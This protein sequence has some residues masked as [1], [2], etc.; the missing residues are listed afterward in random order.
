MCG[1]DCT[2]YSKRIHNILLCLHSSIKC[3]TFG[4][5]GKQKQAKEHS[6]V[7]DNN[8]PFA[9]GFEIVLHCR[10]FLLGVSCIGYQLPCPIMHHVMIKS[11]GITGRLAHDNLTVGGPLV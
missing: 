5:L 7:R 8:Y 4:V 1:N 2:L 9:L 6:D 11:Q 10:L 3:N